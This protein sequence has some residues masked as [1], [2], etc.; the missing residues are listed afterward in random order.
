MALWHLRSKRK[1]TGSK[2]KRLRKKRKLD[3]GSVFLETGIGKGKAKTQKARGNKMKTKLLSVDKANVFDIK[4]KKAHVASIQ[5]VQ[6]NPSNP[7]YVRRNIITK[8]AIIKTELGL[9]KVTSRPGQSGSLSAVL[10]KKKE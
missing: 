4:T 2:L 5:G 9:A 10:I 6:E 8:G 7:H 1:P 3:R